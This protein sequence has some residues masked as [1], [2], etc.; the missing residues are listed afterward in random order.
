M[1]WINNVH[2]LLSVAQRRA[3]TPALPPQ[4]L[5][6]LAAGLDRVPRP[7]GPP[8]QRRL[9]GKRWCFQVRSAFAR[10]TVLTSAADPPR[11]T[12]CS[13]DAPSA[14]RLSTFG[15]C[16]DQ[17]AHHHT[18]SGVIGVVQSKSRAPIYLFIDAAFNDIF[19]T[20]SLTLGVYVLGTKREE[21]AG[22]LHSLSTRWLPC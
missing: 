19:V 12:E 7:R 11:A 9:Q 22:T 13:G 20:A 6:L 4:L 8:R 18:L 3:F 14:L 17:H 16:V 5:G 15:A 2:A 1:T 21:H 10:W